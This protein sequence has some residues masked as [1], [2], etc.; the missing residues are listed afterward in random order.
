[1]GGGSSLVLGQ[2]GR[3]VVNC[4]GEGLHQCQGVWK[5]IKNSGPDGSGISI[6]VTFCDCANGYVKQVKQYNVS[7]LVDRDEIFLDTTVENED[8]RKTLPGS[9]WGRIKINAFRLFPFLLLTAFFG[10]VSWRLLSGRVRDRNRGSRSGIL[11]LRLLEFGLGIFS[12]ALSLLFG[13]FSAI[14]LSFIFRW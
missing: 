8:F 4:D 9:T 1:M 10:T 5:V 7:R 13:F 14:L 2:D 12:F 6:E 11:P 3:L